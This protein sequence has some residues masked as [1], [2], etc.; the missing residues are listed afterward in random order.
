M[1]FFFQEFLQSN[2]CVSMQNEDGLAK[3]RRMTALT[4]LTSR[5]GMPGTLRMKVPIKFGWHGLQYILH[6]GKV[7]LG[8]FC[9]VLLYHRDGRSLAG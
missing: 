1:C 8:G 7:L 6:W 9:M 3:S 5:M 4:S 2:L